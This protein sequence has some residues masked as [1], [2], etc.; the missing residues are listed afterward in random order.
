[1]GLGNVPDGSLLHLSAEQQ[2]CEEKDVAKLPGALRQLHQEAVFHQLTS[3]QRH[4]RERSFPVDWCGRF[5]MTGV[6]EA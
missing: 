2:V 5:L 1:M 4:A 3:L 6:G